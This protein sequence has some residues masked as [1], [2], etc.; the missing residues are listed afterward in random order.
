[1]E[2]EE[3]KDDDKKRDLLTNGRWRHVVARW[4]PEARRWEAILVQAKMLIFIMRTCSLAVPLGFMYKHHHGCF[5]P[6]AAVATLQALYSVFEA[7]QDGVDPVNRR[8]GLLLGTV[9]SSVV[10]LA[11]ITLCQWKWAPGVQG[12]FARLLCTC[13]LEDNA[14]RNF[15]GSITGGLWLLQQLAGRV[16][17]EPIQC[18]QGCSEKCHGDYLYVAAQLVAEL[19]PLF[20]TRICGLLQEMKNRYCNDAGEIEDRYIKIS[21]SKEMKT[22]VKRF[23]GHGGG[24]TLGVFVFR[25]DG[26]ARK[27]CMKRTSALLS[28]FS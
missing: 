5:V 21:G 3:E 22:V 15:A 17:W 23:R 16:P 19:L 14:H 6:V 8:E 2:R 20:D 7:V 11:Y 27:R 13:M 24:L 12:L 18:L 1:M 9:E 4:R 28:L 10:T 26:M 25:G